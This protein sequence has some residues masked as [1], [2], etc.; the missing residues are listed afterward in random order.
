MRWLVLV[1]M[2]LSAQPVEEVKKWLEKPLLDAQQPQVEVQ[3]YTASRVPLV[4]G[5]RTA[6][7]WQRYAEDL[8]SRML[9]EVVYR[10]EARRWRAAPGKVEWLE[11]LEGPGYRVRKLRYQVLPGLVLPALLY[12][13]ARVTGK[14]AAVL[15]VNGHEKT[16]VATPYIQMRCINLAKRGILALNPEWLGRGQLGWEEY[17]HYKMPQIDLTGTSGLAVFYLAMERALDLLVEHPNTDRE[18][19]AVTG[20]SGGGWQTTFISALDTRVKLAVPVA[21]HSSFVTRAQWPALDLGDPEQTPSDMATVADYLH[22][23]AMVAPRPLMLINNA[24]DNC[25]FRA[26]YAPAPLLQVSRAVYSLHGALDKMRYSINHA[27]GHNYNEDSRDELYRFLASHGFGPAAVEA[28]AE[29]EVRTAGQLRVPLPEGNATFRSLALE[30]SRGLPRTDA[31]TREELASLLRIP[32]VEVEARQVASQKA[33]AASVTWWRLKM[34]GAWTVP[35]AEIAPASAGETVILVADEGR[36]SQAARVAELAAAGKRVLAVD[37]FYFGESKIASRDHLFALMLATLGER[38]LGLQAAQIRAVAEWSRGR[39]SRPVSLEA[40]GRR[41]G[42]AA[43]VAA[44]VEERAI[45]SAVLHGALRSLKQVLEED[46]SV[47]KQP[48]MFAFG[49]L[50]A[51]DIPQIAKLVS[52]RPLRME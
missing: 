47:E 23:T 33:G 24:K 7:E 37:P 15:N 10:G 41:T 50:E 16:G 9:N 43:L 21:G 29:S 1:P 28:T 30:L 12:E 39:H 25:C 49:L 26:D 51:A 11:T 44:A 27:A 5:F 8:R 32:A 20:L 4:P 6:A 40:F 2:A 36:R 45:A 48:E 22:M 38:P 31:I 46:L 35:V 19:I 14:V 17:D 52:P 18:R 13:P 34:N 3:V 42:L